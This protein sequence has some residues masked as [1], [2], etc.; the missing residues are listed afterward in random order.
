MFSPSYYN[1][2]VRAPYSFSWKF[3][4][5]FNFLCAV[6]LSLVIAIPISLFNFSG[7]LHQVANQYPADLEIT[8]GANGIQINQPLPYAVPMLLENQPFM[9]EVRMEEG[10]P[11]NLITFVDEQDATFGAQVNQ[12]FDS[13]IVVTPRM[14]YVSE[15]ND[16]E[17][18]N[19]IRAYA[20][21]E[22]QEE[23]VVDQQLID[24]WV[25]QVTDN[26]FVANR[27]YVPLIAL[28]V[29]LV[30]FPFLTLWKVIT[31]AFYSVIVWAI[32]SLGMKDK[33]L[34]FGKVFQIGQHSMTLI[35]VLSILVG[36]LSLF[37]LNGPFYVIAFVVWTLF[38]ISR[39]NRTTSVA[40]S[41]TTT[42]RSSSKKRS[43]A[44]PSTRKKSGSRTTKKK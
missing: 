22:F 20:I 10:V 34:S 11:A 26:P 32:T 5:A 37:T 29:I 27:L 12:V 38:I 40:V 23:M 39:L 30:T 19:E 8:A 21:P 44:A 31:L 15:G 2:V 9:E 3:F 6:L 18:F 4:L 43:K 28:V 17:E 16:P 41:S 7:M 35:S 36:I 1:D 33:N 42:A 25:N 24:G 14:A 13:M